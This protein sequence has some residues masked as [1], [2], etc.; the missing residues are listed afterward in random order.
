MSDTKDVEQVDAVVVGAGFA[1]LYMIYQLRKLGLSVIGFETGADVGGVWYWNRY[2]GARCDIESMQYSYSFAAE[3]EQEWRWSELFATQPE[4][5]RY[6][7][8]VADRFDLRRSIRFNTSISCAE[9]DETGRRWHL[10]TDGDERLS[11]QF[12]I[13]ATGCL[14]TARI[15]DINGLSSFAGRVYHTGQ[16]PHEKVDFTGLRVGVIGTGSSGVQL[17]PIVAKE[18]ANVTVFQRTPT[19]SVPANNKPMSEEYE[20]SWKREYPERRR[21]ARE[22]PVGILR[23]SGADQRSALEVSEDERLKVYEHSWKTAGTGFTAAFK[24][25][26]LS[27]EANATGAEFVRG[28]IRATVKDPRNAAALS[29]TTYP[30]GAKRICVDSQYFETYN[31]PNVS[32]IDLRSSPI[33]RIESRGVRTRDGMNPLDAI[34][35]ATGFDAMTGSLL[36]IDIKGRNGVTLQQKWAGGPATYLGLM[37]SGFPNLFFI[38][39]PGSP[40]VLSNMILSIEQHVEWIADCIAW[41]TARQHDGIEPLLEAELGWV[42][43]V[44]N[45]AAETLYNKANSW[46][47]GANVPGKPR[48]F[49]PYPGGVHVYRSA[50]DRI[51]AQNY[52]GFNLLG[53][54][55]I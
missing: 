4:I 49:M 51:A 37:T 19:F 13:M 42:T 12:C 47:L 48:V 43:H 45:L 55:P 17:I 29:P 15:P 31:R 34:I 27:E 54:T 46:Y 39:G 1:G 38:T 32:L 7:Q 22:T 50:C 2:P 40:S 44:N 25:L 3:L 52:Q 28:K 8:H 18:A 10:R 53:G 6:A 9:F 16:W 33:E 11:A 36:K 30:L 41:L 26:L 20:R 24:D 21:R 23:T 5:L 35:F 14:S